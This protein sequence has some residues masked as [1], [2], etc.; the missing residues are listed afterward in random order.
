MQCFDLDFDILWLNQVKF[1]LKKPTAEP[2]SSVDWLAPSGSST[3]APAF[4]SSLVP[5]QSA[6]CVEA[7]AGGLTADWWEAVAGGL[8]AAWTE[9][10]AGG[11]SAACVEAAAG[12]LTADCG[13]AAA[14]GLADMVE[15]KLLLAGPAGGLAA[16]LKRHF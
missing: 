14:G 12:G 15:G 2:H 10:A 13:E 9:A 6:D 3:A 1:V 4:G 11:L 7:A 16:V 8:T 5:G